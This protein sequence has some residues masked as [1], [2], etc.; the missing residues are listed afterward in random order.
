MGS[1][2]PGWWS[3]KTRESRL[4]NCFLIGAPRRGDGADEGLLHV[5]SCSSWVLSGVRSLGY[6]TSANNCHLVCVTAEEFEARSM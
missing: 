6:S 5:M 3:K 4:Q 1:V 2:P